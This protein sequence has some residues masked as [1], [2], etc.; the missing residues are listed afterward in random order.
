MKKSWIVIAVLLLLVGGYYYFF[1]KKSPVVIGTS[2]AS[3]STPVASDHPTAATQAVVDQVVASTPPATIPVTPTVATQAVIN[4]VVAAAN[5]APTTV[6][7]VIPTVVNSAATIDWTMRENGTPFIDTNLE[8]DVNNQQQ[9]M[10]WSTGQ[11]HLDVNQADSV[12][13]TAVGGASKGNAWGVP[14]TNTLIV[15][16]NGVTICNKTTSTDSDPVN[17]SFIVEGGHAYTILNYTLAT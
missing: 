11:G 3:T 1:Y 6:A 15:T 14:A 17:Y 5:A 13:I 8:I 9:L 10:Q 12:S 16:D 4:Q 2:N 7:S